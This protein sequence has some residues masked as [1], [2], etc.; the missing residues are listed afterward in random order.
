LKERGN[1]GVR[2]IKNLVYIKGLEGA[3]LLNIEVNLVVF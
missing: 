2:L 1:K 3:L